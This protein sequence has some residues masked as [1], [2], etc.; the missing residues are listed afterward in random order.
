MFFIKQMIKMI[1]QHVILPCVYGFWRIVY[2]SREP[3]LIVFADAHHERL[4]YSMKNVYTEIYRRGYQTVDVFYDYSKI[5]MV[6]TFLLAISF[7]KIYAQAR[8]VFI[9]DNFFPV[10]SCYKCKRTKVIQLWHSCGLLKAMG[11]DSKDD[12]P[13][14]YI[15]NV[16]KNYDLVTVSASACVEHFTRAMRQPKGVVQALGVSRTDTYFDQNWAAECRETFYRKYPEAEGKKII[17]WAP[18]FRG[19]AGD[20]Y[21]V[22]TEAI[23]QLEEELG[24]QYFVIRKV[25]P[26]IQ[27]KFHLSNC[28]I[29]SEELLPV[30]DLMITDYSSILYDYMF[31]KKPYVLFAPDIDIYMK[32]RG[33]YVNYETL[34]LY[35]VTNEKEL[36]EKVLVALNE[37]R[38]DW[39]LQQYNYHISACDGHV[40]ERI[41]KYLEV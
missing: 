20:P 18:T 33:F 27:A 36:A 7:M 14:Y 13:S 19:N 15:G 35:V 21:Q 40:T 23:L 37:E 4:P 2:F 1:L 29:S 34:S 16:Y 24:D 39:I 11:Y 17:L 5:P 41:L 6:K 22:G 30:V 10:V 3:Q 32:D 12:I 26:H 8:Y 28:E 31:F 38:S 9:C 25:H